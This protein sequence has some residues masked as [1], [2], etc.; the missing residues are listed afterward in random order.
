MPKNSELSKKWRNS[1]IRQIATNKKNFKGCAV[2]YAYNED[3]RIYSV[4]VNLKGQPY[5][6]TVKV[7][8]D[9][10]EMM[11]TDSKGTLLE[12]AYQNG[13]QLGFKEK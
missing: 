2:Q 6:L 11:L 7:G 5:V 10:L 3:D 12:H 4:K 9:S 8:K 1:K 13:S